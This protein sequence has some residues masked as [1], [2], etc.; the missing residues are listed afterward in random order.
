[1][2]IRHIK[3]ILSTH[4]EE[5]LK[6]KKKI[7]F[8]WVIN[9]LYR[10]SFA[11]GWTILITLFIGHIGIASLP[12][13]F[14]GN[15]LIM[16]VGSMIFSEIITHIS[17]ERLI[18]ST[19]ILG[20]VMLYCAINFILPHSEIWFIITSIVAVGFFIGQI[21]ILMQ[22]FIEEMFS[23]LES[24]KAF[25]I[26]ETGEIIGAIT[27][28]LIL[29]TLGDQIA[30]YKF[31]Y[32]VIL[33]SM[34]IIP[35]IGMFY[36]PH[37]KDEKRNK[38][39][40]KELKEIG[41]MQKIENSLEKVKN[42]GFLKGILVIMLLQ[43]TI[44]NLV[45]FQYTKAIEQTVYSKNTTHTIELSSIAEPSPIQENNTQKEFAQTLGKFHVIVNIFALL[46][47]LFLSGRLLSRLGVMQC[48]LI[49]PILMLFNFGILTYK[50]H[51]GTALIA[52][53][54][55]ESG[56][57]IFQNAYLASYYSIKEELR[58]EI[59]EF[60]EGIIVPLGAIIGTILIFSFE[61]FFDGKS[62][63]LALN[64]TLIVLSLTMAITVY[65]LKESYTSLS[66]KTL[67]EISNLGDKLTSLEILA[68][69]GHAHSGG[70]I[71][72]IA[73]NRFEEVEIRLKAIEIIEKRKPNLS[74]YIKL[75]AEKSSRIQ[76]LILRILNTSNLKL[77]TV[78][79][80]ELFKLIKL[81][82]RIYKKYEKD[83]NSAID[84][85]FK[86]SPY[87]T[88]EFLHSLI[89]KKGKHKF[90][91]IKILKEKHLIDITTKPS[92]RIPKKQ[93][94]QN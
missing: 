37:S 75:L 67:L 20:A 9:Y 71:E 27:A 61:H 76:T 65:K 4:T 3:S 12:Y 39:G 32:V 64:S 46:T 56:K 69:E 38:I 85:L 58:E 7:A 86:L 57:A 41:K 24:E 49:H 10:T 36:K 54:G 13:L 73:K 25:P 47:N 82:K 19:L 84:I 66:K 50:F 23:P 28:G 29:T 43:Y 59:K 87:D 78:S 5:S 45:E 21:H 31:F 94:L 51:I 14:T 72:S 26:V 1:M 80:K 34:T 52:K 48:L 33:V 44:F 90:N 8:A 92:I 6:L 63:T 2:L 93:S 30:P 91:A 83:S 53:T 79:F 35:V 70:L 68:Q 88:Y 89:R 62:M 42:T 74:L 60:M 11:L 55:F 40:L 81:L 77:N 15:A 18:S 17:K 22:L 16:M